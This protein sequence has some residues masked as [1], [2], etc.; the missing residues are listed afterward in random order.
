MLYSIYLI[1]YF[2]SHSCFVNVCSHMF[3][4]L[5]QVSSRYFRKMMGFKSYCCF[6]V[7]Y[8]PMQREK[9]CWKER[10]LYFP[11]LPHL[12]HTSDALNT[13]W[14]DRITITVRSKIFWLGMFS[15]AHEESLYRLHCDWIGAL[16]S[17]QCPLQWSRRWFICPMMTARGDDGTGCSTGPHQ[18]QFSPLNLL[19]FFGILLF[20]L[21]FKPVSESSGF[22]VREDYIYFLIQTSSN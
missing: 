1:M 9:M 22:R 10:V 4:A 17:P 12:P 3:W 15:R 8:H 16:S 6:E 21:E 11:E 2:I 18:N 7:T 5:N 19:L 14:G 20:I 13:P